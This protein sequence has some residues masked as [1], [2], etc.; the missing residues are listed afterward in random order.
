MQRGVVFAVLCLTAILVSAPLRAAQHSADELAKAAQNS[1]ANMI[2]VPFQNDLN[3]NYGPQSSPQDILNIQPVMPVTL[4]SDQNI[5]TRTII[6]IISQPALAP[7]QDSQTGVGD[8]QL[9]LFLSPGSVKGII[10]GVG[11]IAQLPTQSDSR[12]GSTLWEFGPTAV[13]LRIEGPWVYGALI[14]NVSSLGGGAKG[15]DN[16]LMQPFVNYKFGKTGTYLV[17]SPIITANWKNGDWTVP[18]GGGMGQIFKVFG[19]RPV[20]AFLQAYY[21]VAR[22]EDFGPEW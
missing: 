5:I 9:S 6:P 16:S 3:F 21:N 22:R 12:L 15:Y 7:G 13:A 17:T 2:S 4:N 10:R 18:L 20:N 11:M 1:I 8:T 14:S 19:R